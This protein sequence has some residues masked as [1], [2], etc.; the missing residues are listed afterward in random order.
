[1]FAHLHG[2]DYAV[3]LCKPARFFDGDTGISYNFCDFLDPIDFLDSDPSFWRTGRNGDKSGIFVWLVR[4]PSR[5]DGDGQRWLA[6]KSVFVQSNFFTVCSLEYFPSTQRVTFAIFLTMDQ[7]E[8]PFKEFDA[9][10]FLYGID[11]CICCSHF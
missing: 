3:D 2:S 1:M 8:H 10:V 4:H 5:T 7:N 9:L 6:G 11:L